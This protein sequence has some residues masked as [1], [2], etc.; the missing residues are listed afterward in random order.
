MAIIVPELFSRAVLEQM[1]H[2]LRIGR[3]A[4]DATAEADD[5]KITQAGDIVH[6]PVIKRT[7]RSVEVVQGVPLVPAELDMSD[8]TA[9]IKHMAVPY[10]VYDKQQ[11]QVKPGVLDKVVEDISTEM[12]RTID[13]DLVDTMDTEA[14]YKEATDAPD[15]ITLNELYKGMKC[16]GD[17]VDSA[18]FA[19]IIINSRLWE[20]FMNM[21][22]FI[23]TDYTFNNQGNGVIKDGV[24]GYLFG[25]VPVIICDNNTFDENANECKTYFVKKHS[26]GYI[27]QRRVMIEEAR[28]LRLLATDIVASA[29][30]CTKLLDNKG[31]VILRKTA[32]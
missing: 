13:A 31:A 29:L 6:F 11:I 8:M 20:S 12:A 23:K 7:A 24:I 5:G 22:P 25:G 3:V 26:L 18:S 32:A 1:P 27:F 9:Q 28:A 14:V 19:G 16:F 30:Y 21:P 2:S 10:T 17:S 4:Y 15:S